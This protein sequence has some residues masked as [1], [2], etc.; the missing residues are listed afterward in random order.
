MGINCFPATQ[1]CQIRSN[2]VQ[3]LIGRL[4]K[5]AI[6]KTTFLTLITI[7]GLAA[8]T[9]AAKPE[10]VTVR[11]GHH[12]TAAHSGI[13]IKFISVVEDSRCPTDAQ[14]VWAGNAKIEVLISDKMGGS[15]KMVMNT[16]MGPAGDQYNGWAIN[17]TSLSP[18]R[19]TN[20]KKGKIDYKATFTITRLQR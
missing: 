5:E 6:M 1:S 15:K 7:L 19:K 14:C 17:L 9:M 3:R 18:V 12:K 8:M 10:T 2:N 11:V 20:D 4:Q 13:T 16:G